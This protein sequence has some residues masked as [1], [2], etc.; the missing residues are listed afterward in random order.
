[1]EPK[2]KKPLP[3]CYTYPRPRCSLI[4][5]WPRLGTLWFDLNV[6]ATVKID[7][8]PLTPARWPSFPRRCR[9]ACLGRRAA[10]A[11]EA[12]RRLYIPFVLAC[13]PPPSLAVS[14]R[15]SAGLLSS[16]EAP[17]RPS[18]TLAV[19]SEVSQRRRDGSSNS[20]REQL[21][22]QLACSSVLSVPAATRRLASEKGRHFLSPAELVPKRALRP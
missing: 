7:I 5:L 13:A 12:S 4:E 10:C 16:A 19:A 6:L 9:F 11:S 2:L 17:V 22:I 21:V 14:S 3:L 8:D 18:P 20:R 15:L 1:L